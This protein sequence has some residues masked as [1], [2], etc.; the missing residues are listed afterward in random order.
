MQPVRKR[1]A[2]LLAGSGVYDGSE[3]ME[4]TS[5]FFALHEHNYDFQCFAPDW[6]QHHVVNHTD[7]SEMEQTRNVLA[8][9]ARIARGDVK[10]IT[11]LKTEDYDVLMIP[12]GF[13]AAKNLCDYAIKG[14]DMT[15]RPEIEDIVNDFVSNKKVI[16]ASCIAPIILAKV[17]PKCTITLGNKG[18]NWPYAGTIDVAEGFGATCV[19]TEADGVTIDKE[20]LIVTAP[21]FMYD[22]KNY[23]EILQNLRGLVTGVNDLLAK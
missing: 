7:G 21:A 17:V 9:S 10:N 8:E 19:L 12:G 5:M 15:V 4:T 16:A 1:A 2:I 6:D 14:A 20:N 3:I 23:H 22:Q 18:D 13:G 11:E